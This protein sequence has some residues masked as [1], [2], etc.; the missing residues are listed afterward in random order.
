MKMIFIL[1]MVIVA[2]LSGCS[3]PSKSIQLTDSDYGPYP[4]N[5]EL[6]VKDHFEMRLFDPFSAQYKFSKPPSN[7]YTRK[8]PIVGGGIDEVGWIVVVYVNAKNRMGGYVGWKKYTLL[9]NYN[10]AIKEIFPNMY[11]TEWWYI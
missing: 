11:F 1:I 3:T 8:A 9:I 6:I 4:N 7:G 5:Y 10:Q 2:L